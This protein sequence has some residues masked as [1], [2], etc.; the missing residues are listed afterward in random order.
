MPYLTGVKEIS[1][2]F[3]QF[4]PTWIKFA[5]GDDSD[6]FIITSFVKVGTVD[7][8]LRG[9]SLFCLL[10]HSRCRGFLFSLYHIQTHT[11]VGRTPLDEG[12]GRRRH[13]Y[14]STQTL[15]KRHTSIP[16]VGFEPMIPASARPQTYALDC[17]APG[18]GWHT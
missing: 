14:L 12:S 16:P 6:S 8:T 18:I 2:C 3:V 5:T 17:T 15:Y 9:P 10:V 1:L 13:L 7:G 4:H 11:A